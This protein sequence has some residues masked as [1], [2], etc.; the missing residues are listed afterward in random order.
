M[1]ASGRGGDGGLRQKSG[2]QVVEE[3]THESRSE[4]Q[5]TLFAEERAPVCCL[6]SSYSVYFPVVQELGS[7]DNMAVE[8]GVKC[9]KFLLFFFNFIFWLCG[10][11]VIV[12]GVLAQLALHKT[13]VIQNA[14]GSAVPIV[15]I[16]V[17]VIIFFIAFFGCCGAAKENY[18]MVTMFAILLSLIVIVEVGVVIAGYIYKGKLQCCGINSTRDWK[19]FNQNGNSVPDSCCKNVSKDCGLGKMNDIN[20]VFQRGCEEALV[21]ELEKNM[22]WVIVGALVIAFIEILGIVFACVLMK[23]IR[24]GYEVM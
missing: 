13:L 7:S 6:T 20:T 9:V 2:R 12:V 15:F 23:G 17:G 24:S 3:T 19:S 22:K 14:S 5:P 16:V 4:A 21:L 18:C 1:L 10:L 8:G 11:F